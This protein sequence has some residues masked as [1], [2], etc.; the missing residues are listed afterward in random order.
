MDESESDMTE[1]R[2]L[3]EDE[4]LRLLAHFFATVDLHLVE[5][6]FYADRR[7][8]EGTLPLID[9]MVRDGDPVGRAWLET[10]R[11]DIQ[12]ALANRGRDQQAYEDQLHEV[13]GRIA[14]EIKRRRE[15]LTR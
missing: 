5:G 4:A 14:T 9:A 10:L 6:P 11:S 3:A 2:I 12:N 7:I 13:P 1:R 8:I 15:E